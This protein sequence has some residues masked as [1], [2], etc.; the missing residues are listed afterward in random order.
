MDVWLAFSHFYAD[1]AQISAVKFENFETSSPS[2][3]PSTTSLCA[4][5]NGRSNRCNYQQL[6]GAL[7][8]LNRRPSIEKV[9][10]AVRSVRTEMSSF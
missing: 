6:S 3:L 7:H 1:G 10:K 8:G 4:G 2:C 5:R 9:S